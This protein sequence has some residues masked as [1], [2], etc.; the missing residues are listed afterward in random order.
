MVVSGAPEH[1]ADASGSPEQLVLANARAKATAVWEC[2]GSEAAERVV[3]GI[4]TDVVLDGTLLGKP[5]DEAG[6]RLRLERLSGRTH[7]VLSAVVALG[8]GESEERSGVAV[9]EVRFRELSE[10]ILG[11]YL[12]SEEWRDRAGAYAVQGL[13]AMLVDGVEGDLSNVIGLP[14]ALFAQLV[15][16][17]FPKP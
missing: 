5:S 11:L 14:L 1:G 3:V 7:L 9:S 15:P 16:E 17:F 6:A 2:L 8:P 4:D 13:G 10:G 12:D